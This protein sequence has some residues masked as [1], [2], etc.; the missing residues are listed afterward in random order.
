MFRGGIITGC[1]GWG[2]A[3]VRFTGSYFEVGVGDM[4]AA[5]SLFDLIG[6]GGTL[7][8]HVPNTDPPIRY[9]VD[10]QTLTSLTKMRDEFLNRNQRGR[11]RIR[12]PALERSSNR[13][14]TSKLL[15]AIC[16]GV[17]GRFRG[18]LGGYGGFETR[19]RKPLRSRNH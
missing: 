19:E 12:G 10:S 5:N 3:L 2:N 11:T 15:F 16:G 6:R 13:S 14:V 9:L 1:S 8:L 17:V 7:K 4:R 18:S